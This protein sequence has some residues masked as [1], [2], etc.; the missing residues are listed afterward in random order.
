MENNIDLYKELFKKNENYGFLVFEIQTYLSQTR[1]SMSTM[2][3]IEKEEYL[4]ILNSKDFS[5][6]E[7][8]ICSLLSRRS[9][10]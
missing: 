6:L 3:N 7:I 1:N 2:L 4:Q 5:N 9:S 8:I 10:I